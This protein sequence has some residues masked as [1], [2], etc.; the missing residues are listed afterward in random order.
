M[1]KN[2]RNHLKKLLKVAEKKY[3][4]DLISKCKSDSKEVWS[5]IKTVINKIEK[6]QIQKEFRLGD[7]SLTSDMKLICNKFNEFFVNVG[8]SLSKKIPTQNTMPIDYIKNR[9][10]Y[11]IYLEPVSEAEIKKLISS[12]KSNTPGY[13]MIGSAVLKW[14]VDSISEPLSYVCNMSLQEGLISGELKIANVIPFYKCDDSK[15]F[16]N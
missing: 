1:Y 5:I 7:G 11:S 8:P 2:Y 9:A 12:L 13:D 10:I 6:S 3:Y 16:N 15:L 4:C 14:C